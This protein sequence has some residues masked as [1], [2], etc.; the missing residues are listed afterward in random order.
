MA[1]QTNSSAHPLIP[2]LKEE[3][4]LAW[5]RLLRSRRVGIST[6]YRLLEEHGTAQSALEHLPEVARAA[7][8]DN[9]LPHCE[10][11]AI[12]EMRR[13]QKADA[14]L[15]FRGTPAYP[16]AFNDLNDA[17]PFFRAVGDATLLH[18]PTLGLVGTRNASYLGTRMSRFLATTLG[19]EGYV[20]CSG[21]AR[22]VDTAAHA[23]AIGTG[24]IALL[25]GGVDV[26]YPAENAQ[27]TRQIRENGLLISEQPMG[28][29]PQARHFPVRN[30]LIS[31]LSR[32]IVVIEAAAKSGSLITAKTALDQGRDVYAVPGHPFDARTSG[33]NILIRDGA[34]LVRNEE[35]IIE[36]LP[37]LPPQTDIIYDTPK[38]L[39]NRGL[40]ETAK[41]HQRILAR[42]SPSPLAE[43]QLIRDL[44]A[45]AAQIA[46]ALVD[47]EIEGQI[48]R[49]SGGMVSLSGN[50]HKD[51]KGH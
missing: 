50:E 12:A 15:I 38:P 29:Q 5:L 6:F 17:P 40:R 19:E 10:E 8:V 2:P 30:R 24:T 37:K 21:L 35:D 13:G 32:A 9:Y 26:I 1:V 48:E 34:T 33:C 27:L 31:G 44:K 16:A 18:L 39:P 7:S 47:L 14:Q 22:G 36:A 4:R 41:L 25:G 28:T 43:D 46:P 11:Q 23:A 42:L 20:I 51:H 3:D 45:S 49:Q